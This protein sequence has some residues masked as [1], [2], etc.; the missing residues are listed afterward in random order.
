MGDLQKIQSEA[1]IFNKSAA[2]KIAEAVA[3]GTIIFRE[4]KSYFAHVT[5]RAHNIAPPNLQ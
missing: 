3:I 4:A 1:F 5:K 2:M